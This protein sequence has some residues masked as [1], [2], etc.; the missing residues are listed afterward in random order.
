MGA[1]LQSEKK[2]EK[3]EGSTDLDLLAFESLPLDF[4]FQ[5]VDKGRG[6]LIPYLGPTQKSKKI[7]SNNNN[8]NYKPIRSQS[9]QAR[10]AYSNAA[11]GI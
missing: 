1:Q 5:R 8:S 3:G 6:R 2:K 9:S 11:Q 4:F 10:S 7:Y